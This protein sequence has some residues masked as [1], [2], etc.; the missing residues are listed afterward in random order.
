[1]I[2]KKERPAIRPDALF[3]DFRQVTRPKQEQ[4]QPPSQRQRKEEQIHSTS[5]PRPHHAAV[6]RLAKKTE[7][8]LA[9]P[10]VFRPPRRAFLLFLFWAVQWTS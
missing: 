6:Q 5:T 2:Y 8:C 3:F 9:R 10:S 4:P 1:M 7:A